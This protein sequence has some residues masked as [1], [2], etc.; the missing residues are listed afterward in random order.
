MAKDTE[1]RTSFTTVSGQGD[2]GGGVT[3]EDFVEN[4]LAAVVLST[5]RLGGNTVPDFVVP[6]LICQQ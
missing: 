3:G 5:V 2:D 6:V 1:K 4:D